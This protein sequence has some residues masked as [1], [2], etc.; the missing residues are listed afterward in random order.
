MYGFVLLPV[1]L[2]RCLPAKSARQNTNIVDGVV[3]L[4]P[5][6]ILHT[7]ICS[8]YNLYNRFYV[9]AVHCL[10]AVGDMTGSRE[11]HHLQLKL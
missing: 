1:Y 7:K 8:M 5:I 10:A 9:D 2:Q 6:Y 11:E 3:Q 4:C